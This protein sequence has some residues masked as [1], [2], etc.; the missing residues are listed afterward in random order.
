MAVIASSDA[1]AEVA[2][3][4]MLCVWSGFRGSEEDWTSVQRW[5]YVL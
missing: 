1:A 2:K 3:N 4:F 5:W